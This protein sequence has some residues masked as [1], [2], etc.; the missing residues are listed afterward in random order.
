V[1][2]VGADGVR[3]S[4]I[5]GAWVAVAG[6]QTWLLAD[7]D[8]SSEAVG[9]LWELQRGDAGHLE[10][11]SALAGLGLGRIPSF[12][13]AGLTATGLTVVLRGAGRARVG[14][15]GREAE[16]TAA[17]FT[18]WSEHSFE[19]LEGDLELIGE[20]GAPGLD[21]PLSA[22]VVR[23]CR[24]RLRFGPSAAVE[25]GP[26]AAAGRAGAAAPG[27][28][29][30]AP[31]T[32]V[33]S[34]VRPVA[35]EAVAA[36]AAAPVAPE[37]AVAPTTA[38]AVSEAVVASAAAPAA[39]ATV[40]APA[41]APVTPETA[42]APA[43]A[44]VTPETAVAPTTA[45]A[46]S[47]AVV[48]SAAAPAAPATVLAPAAAPVAPETVVA[49]AVAPEAPEVPQAAAEPP[50]A[51]L[52]AAV[53]RNFREEMGLTASGAEATLRAPIE[54]GPHDAPAGHG[55]PSGA[56]LPRSVESA[57]APAQ[58][59]EDPGLTARPA[60]PGIP[61]AAAPVRVA[62]PSGGAPPAQPAIPP[63]APAAQGRGGLI[64]RVPWGAPSPPPSTPATPAPV[65]SPMPPG[66]PLD[67]TDGLTISRE[68]QERLLHRP[69]APGELPRP[70]PLVHAVECPNGHPNPAHAVS[71]RICH[72]A[73]PDTTPVTVPRPVLGV[74]R[75]STGDA[76]PL[77]RG[78]LMGRGPTASRLVDGERPHLVKIP[79]PD[80]HISRT[81]L[82]IRL[83]EWHVLVTD[84]GSTNGTFVTLPGRDPERL[85][86]DTPMPIEPGATVA[87]AD[88]VT[89]RF[90]V[91]E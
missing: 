74:L 5:P 66:G 53:T 1:T 36:P 65:G 20:G 4:Y 22:G 70:G 3:A 14:R 44:P 60:R 11:L 17:G 58:D 32:V 52:T 55:H 34:R 69:A 83:D 48:A 18:T 41:A 49:P 40:L 78:V 86:P 23:A 12:A 63:P 37:T 6:R 84:L 42:V 10:I 45:P 89:F 88:E 77:D 39:P 81:H 51:T 80:K 87:L 85:R 64:D 29:P 31:E 38:P 27:V 59:T 15:E 30:V 35:P 57:A 47:E 43:A 67:D 75:M 76:I 61:A 16:L 8:P 90:E 7:L 71:C 73:V 33:A 9:Q 62:A 72:A 50:A 68:V 79:S 46:A 82:E 26:P 21:L 13:L 2:E 28:R 56:T 19:H 24:L 91:G 25:A 54:A